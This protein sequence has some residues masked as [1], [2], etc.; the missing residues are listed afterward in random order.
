[1]TEKSKK[2]CEPSVESKI[3]YLSLV[4]E[5]TK[6]GKRVVLGELPAKSRKR[7]LGNRRILEVR[8]VLTGLDRKRNQGAFL[9]EASVHSVTYD[10]FGDGKFVDGISRSVTLNDRSELT[11]V[12]C[13]WTTRWSGGE[14]HV[15]RVLAP[16]RVSR[17]ELHSIMRL[18][19]RTFK[20]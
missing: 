18:V 13:H 8:A 1:M 16:E 4:R 9:C 12:V 5:I 10:E 17:N 15:V 6:R 2:S 3:K 7:S 14:Y 20:S 19:R 11:K